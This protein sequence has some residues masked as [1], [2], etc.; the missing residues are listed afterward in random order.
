ML[1]RWLAAT[2]DLSTKNRFN[3]FCN[4]MKIKIKSF[5]CLKSIRNYK[6]NDAWNIRQLVD[7]SFVPASHRAS[8]LYCRLSDLDIISYILRGD[9][10]VSC[11]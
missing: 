2:N 8:V 7:E 3:F 1:A 5:E 9:F 10:Q 11:C 6:K 4:S